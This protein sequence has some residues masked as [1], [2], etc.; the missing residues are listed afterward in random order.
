MDEE[1]MIS[2]AREVS[3]SIHRG[4]APG[5]DFSHVERVYRLA[6]RMARII[7]EIEKEAMGL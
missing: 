4:F 6:E 2:G 5:H 1:A 3:A 7:E